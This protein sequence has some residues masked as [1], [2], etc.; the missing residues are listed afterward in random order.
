VIAEIDA[1]GHTTHFAYDILGRMIVVH[2][3]DG[4]IEHK[5]YDTCGNLTKEIDA[6]GYVTQKTYNYRGQPLAI[7]YPDGSEEHFTYYP[8]GA[9]ATHIDKS[10]SKMVYTYDSFDRPIRIETYASGLLKTTTA[11]YTPFQKISETDGEGILTTYTYDFAGRTIAKQT[12]RKKV[13]YSYDSLGFLTRTEQLSCASITQHNHAGHPIEK[14]TEAD[15]LQFQER[16]AYN[17]NGERTHLITSHGAFE[18]I[19]NT[20][21]QPLF[22]KDPLG[23]T[24]S[25]TYLS[26][27]EYIETTTDANGI[28]TTHIYDSRGRETETHLKNTLGEIIAKQTNLYNKNGNLTDLTHFVYDGSHLIQRITHHWN[29]GPMG[30][31]DSFLEAGERETRNAYDHKGRLLTITK[32]SGSVLSHEWDDLGRLARYFS[33]D[34][35]YQYTY[36]RNDRLLSVY[37]AVS[38]RK[39]TRTYNALGN[40]TQEILS[41]GYQLLHTFDA[42]GRRIESTLPDNSTIDYVYQGAYLHSVNRNGLHFTYTARDL[43]GHLIQADL[44]IGSIAIERD[45]LSRWKHYDSPF[46]HSKSPQ[47]DPVGNLLHYH[48]QDSLGKVDCVYK[49]DDLNQLISENDHTYSFDS[50]NNR[51]RKDDLSHQVNH[52]CQIIDDGRY[53][54]DL[55]GNLIFDGEWHYTYDTQNRLITLENKNKR[56]EC[57]Y[58]PFHRRL[59]KKVFANG[60]V[61]HE[62]YLWDGDNEIGVM[63]EQGQIEQLRILGEGLGAEIGAAV[64]YELKGKAYIP[65]HDHRGC[66]VTLIDMESKQPLES[67]RYTAFGEE[68]TDGRLSPWRFASKRVDETGLI[69]FGRRYYHPELGRWISQDPQGFEDGPNLYAYLHNCPLTDFDLYGLFGFGSMWNNAQHFMWGMLEGSAYHFQNMA[70]SFCMRD[71]S[72]PE[73]KPKSLMQN[74]NMV[75]TRGMD[76]VEK[77]VLPFTYEARRLGDVS[78][79]DCMRARGRA[80]GEQAITLGGLFSAFSLGKNLL[81]VGPRLQ[82]M[83]TQGLSREYLFSGKPTINGA[84]TSFT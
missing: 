60:Q 20:F 35:D 27:R 11:A 3:P 56:I 65:I 55:D 83:T 18:T 31:I 71:F 5:E 46:Y 40:I 57:E 64:L 25:H 34:F 19:Y 39:T 41:S 28:Q 37:D 77:S 36:D 7:H 66:V 9:L 50:L 48:Y 10:G 13:C 81:N 74:Q 70:S 78:Q 32:P 45:A 63:N 68:L 15:A 29:Y 43:E 73:W 76:W 21:G 49:Y 61:K 12:D 24:T 84:E 4:A 59:S 79:N 58:D 6:E 69:F 17:E 26:G 38:K 82:E 62:R 72:Q 53:E 22:E 67:Y 30:R 23:F 2:H 54:Y 1:C 47:Y 44:P 80:F 42:E 16:Y 52:L 33:S 75:S 14:R 51:L 8:Q